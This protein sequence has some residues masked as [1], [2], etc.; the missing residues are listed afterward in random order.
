MKLIKYSLGGNKIEMGW[1]ETNEE[2]AKSESD[3]GE[4]TIEDDGEPEPDVVIST[5][6]RLEALEMAMLE[7][8]GV[9]VDG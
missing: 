9:S 5:E 2:I 3:N 1:N 6:E 8:M 4:Y 7:M